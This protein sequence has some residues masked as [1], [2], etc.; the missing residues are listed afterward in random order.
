LLQMELDRTFHLRDGLYWWGP[1]RDLASFAVFV[2]SF[3]GRNVEWRGHHYGVQADN[4]LAYYG[5]VET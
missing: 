2:A 1:L 3:F 5:E 4:T